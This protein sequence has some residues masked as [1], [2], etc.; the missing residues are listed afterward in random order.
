MGHLLPSRHSLRLRGF[1]YAGAGLYFVTVGTHRRKNLFGHSVS[2]R[3]ELSRVGRIVRECWL[4]IP[5]HFGHVGLDAYV[6]MP[7]HF[8]GILVLYRKTKSDRAQHAAPLQV[9]KSVAMQVAPASLAA[10][11]RSFKSAAT[12]SA[13][14]KLSFAGPLWQRNYYE[15]IIR[16]GSELEEIRRYIAENPNRWPAFCKDNP[17]G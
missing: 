6:L 13:R 5:E 9:N 2:G 4:Y 10:T 7:D 11:V 17:E 3:V 16:N 1:D 8:H 15:H 12:R 14:Q